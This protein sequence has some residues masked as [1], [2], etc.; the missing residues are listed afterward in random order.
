MPSPSPTAAPCRRGSTE[1]IS[2]PAGEDDEDDAPHC[3]HCPEGDEPIDKGRCEC[4]NGPNTREDQ[5]PTRPPSTA[6]SPPGSRLRPRATWAMAYANNTPC[7]GTANPRITKARTRTP[8]SQSQLS[9][10]ATKTTLPPRTDT[11]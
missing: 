3:R 6:P 4:W 8:A 9:T 1:P 7:Q 10:E 2:P 11:R 5:S